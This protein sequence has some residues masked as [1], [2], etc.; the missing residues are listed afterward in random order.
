MNV[1]PEIALQFLIKDAVEHIKANPELIDEI[2]SMYLMP[3]YAAVYGGQT[4]IDKIKEWFLSTDIPVL[5]SWSFNSQQIPAISVHLSDE[6]EDTAQAALG[7]EFSEIDFDD[8]SGVE[9]G[10]NCFN[11]SLDVGIHSAKEGDYVL[12]LYYITQFIFFLFKRDFEYYGLQLHTYRA[13]AFN[14]ES[15]YLANNVWS[16]WIRINVKVYNTWNISSYDKHSLA[17]NT[18]IQVG[19][20]STDITNP[21]VPILQIISSTP[22]ENNGGNE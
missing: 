11:V 18:N 16:R 19:L 2:F 15:K 13:S 9:E 17:Y 21:E 12:W 22:W 4:Y 10:I 14:K 5:Q 8:G 6:V 1:M 3:R 7:D 20:G